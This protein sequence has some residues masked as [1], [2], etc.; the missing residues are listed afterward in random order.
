MTKAKKFQVKIHG[1][2]GANNHDERYLLFQ[3]GLIRFSP[4]NE[5]GDEWARHW[6]YV[7]DLAFKSG[8]LQF[9][10]TRQEAE[11]LHGQWVDVEDY[12]GIDLGGQK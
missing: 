11:D 2:I 4:D 9:A 3:G 6:I 5:K 12:G 10:V 7:E 8:L 1:S